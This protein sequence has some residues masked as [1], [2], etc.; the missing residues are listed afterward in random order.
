M[1]QNIFVSLIRLYLQNQISNEF[2]LR[3]EF[4]I[5]QKDSFATDK[6]TNQDDL[7]EMADDWIEEDDDI[8]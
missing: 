7:Y 6:R 2:T 8:V 3:C 4:S 1:I 5:S